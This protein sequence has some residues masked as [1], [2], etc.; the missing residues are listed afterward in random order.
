MLRILRGSTRA[1][2]NQTNGTIML[3]TLILTVWYGHKS[4]EVAAVIHSGSQRTYILTSTARQI[5]LTP[6]VFENTIQYLRR[7]YANKETGML[8]NRTF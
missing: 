5:S 7:C 6:V 8:G 4:M 1:L 2:P 3:Q